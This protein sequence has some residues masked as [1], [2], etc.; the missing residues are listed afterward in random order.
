MDP[1]GNQSS[2]GRGKTAGG[3]PV[4][5]GQGEAGTIGLFWPAGSGATQRCGAAGGGLEVGPNI[6]PMSSGVR[7]GLSPEE[8]NSETHSDK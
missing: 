3:L 5:L 7:G 2:A 1:R 6:G 8:S 4:V